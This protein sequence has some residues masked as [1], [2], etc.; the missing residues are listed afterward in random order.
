MKPARIIVAG[1]G[2]GSPQ[3]VTPAVAE[4]L[5]Q[6]DVIIGYKYYFR[7]VQ[8]FLRPDT[9]CMDTGMKKERDRVE[10]AFDEAEKGKT[11]CITTPRRSC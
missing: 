8:P 6:S 11:V 3:D 4:A 2:P 5:R 9:E 7:F 1:I 10:A